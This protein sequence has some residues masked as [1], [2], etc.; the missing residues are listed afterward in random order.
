MTAPAAQ[1]SA[2]LAGGFLYDFRILGGRTL[3]LL[4]VSKNIVSTLLRPVIFFLAFSL[5]LHGILVANGVDFGQFFPPAIIAQT[6][7]FAAMGTAFELATDNG[8]GLLSRCRS[9]PIHSGAVVCARLVADGA[10]A[11]GYLVVAVAAG[12]VVGF[13]FERGVGW[14]VVFVL[15]AVL[16][17]VALGLAVAPI[18]IRSTRPQEIGPMMFM[19]LIPLV[20]FSSA[21]VPVTAFPEWLRPVVQLSPFTSE[22][23]ALRALSTEG[24]SLTPVWHAAAWIAGLTLVFGW[25][26]A[27]TWRRAVR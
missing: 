25:L 1:T 13:R 2:P 6:T 21:F 22:V 8:N 19:V 4:L 3:R 23:E 12:F 18:G 24:A 14:A 27:R 26:S 11:F 17:A 20:N 15:V 10:Q 5:V 9:L 16:F 7:G